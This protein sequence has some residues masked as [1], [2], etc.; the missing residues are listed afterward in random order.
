MSGSEDDARR[1]QRV[2]V[3]TPSGRDAELTCELLEREGF[4]CVALTNVDELCSAMLEGGSAAL[5]AFPLSAI[6][7]LELYA[8]KPCNLADKSAPEQQD[9]SDENDALDN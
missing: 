5:L 9:A 3:L 6:S 8:Q 2:L 7:T 4:P 1:E